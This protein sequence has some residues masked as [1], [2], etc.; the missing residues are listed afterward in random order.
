MSV[1]PAAPGRDAEQ[2]VLDQ[3]SRSAA[4]N[5]GCLVVRQRFFR[6]E[7]PLGAD[8][9]VVLFH[10]RPEGCTLRSDDRV[11]LRPQ[12]AGSWSAP[13]VE[14]GGFVGQALGAFGIFASRHSGPATELGQRLL[15]AGQLA[16]GPYQRPTWRS[17]GL[18]GEIDA[19]T[20]TLRAYVDLRSG[21]RAGISYCDSHGRWRGFKRDGGAW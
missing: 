20:K 18:L 3:C 17:G 13:T 2:V 19:L 10:R 4:S 21:I 14:S 11:S 12:F 16:V 15:I 8:L 7:A 6:R 1:A 5:G 9:R